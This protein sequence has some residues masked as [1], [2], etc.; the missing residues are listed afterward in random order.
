MTI[1]EQLTA[2][3]TS[4]AWTQVE[5]ANALDVSHATLNSW[6]RGRSN[7]RQLART[8][9][10]L[11]YL[12]IVGSTTVD[13]ETLARAKKQALEK[14]FNLQ[15]FFQSKDALDVFTL[16]FTYHT[17][18]I[19]GSTMTLSDVEAVLFDDKV[20]ANRSAVEQREAQNHR[21]ALLWLIDQVNA[22]GSAF[23]FSQDLILG[24]HLRLMNGIITNAGMYR[25]HNV[26]ILGVRVPLAN[27]LSIPQRIEEL[28]SR[29]NRNSKDIIADLAATHADFEQ[30]HPFSDG[31]GRCGR[32]LMLAQAA[33]AAC[34]PPIVIKERRRAYYKY[35]ECAQLT[36]DNRPL[37]QFFT[38]SMQFTAELL[39]PFGV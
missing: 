24:L 13:D 18:T 7:P 27:H 36:N 39:R 8:R 26:R 23:E 33:R 5:L 31:N 14:S 6:L 16:Q 11:L 32:L 4:A 9:I 19:E 34:Y 12:T 25:D 15:S 20:L 3:Q 38:E 21:A 29:L 2:I 22:Q 37:E 28:I 17:N 30:I 10:E 35:L 1:I